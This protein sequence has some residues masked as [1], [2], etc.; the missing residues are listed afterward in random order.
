MPRL[1]RHLAQFLIT[2]CSDGLQPIFMKFGRHGDT[3]KHLF[4]K[5]PA[6][7]CQKLGAIA[8]TH[9]I[10]YLRV[11]DCLGHDFK[12]KERPFINI[13]QCSPRLPARPS[14]P[15]CSHSPAMHPFSNQATG[16]LNIKGIGN[17]DTLTNGTPLNCDEVLDLVTKITQ[18]KTLTGN[19]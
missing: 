17:A 8:N 1:S 14:R 10:D 15:N 9:H 3:A 4:P 12:T 16:I 7:H 11:V 18:D 2:K 5:E 13:R 6:A 19:P